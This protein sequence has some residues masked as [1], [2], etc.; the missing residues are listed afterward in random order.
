MK[1]K[2]I[3]INFII[4]GSILLAAV[5]FATFISLLFKGK[6]ISAEF[7]FRIEYVF[8]FIFGGTIFTIMRYL[9]EHF[10]K[11]DSRKVVVFKSQII[12]YAILLGISIILLI[13]SIY[14]SIEIL[15]F[16]SIAFII[17]IS[18]YELGLNLAN[19]ELKKDV[20]MINEKLKDNK[21][22]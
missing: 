4:F 8:V 17:A 15:K 20:E 3:L 14:K 11:K 13:Y 2:K 1:I 18:I 10:T 19:K 9:V 12:I 21:K 5:L 6:N 7:A 22:Q 16:F